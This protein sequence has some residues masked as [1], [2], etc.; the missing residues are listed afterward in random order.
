[1]TSPSVRR[2]HPVWDTVLSILL[3][4]FAFLIAIFSVF[5]QIVGFVFT[6][7]CPRTCN[8]ALGTEYV[9]WTWAVMALIFIAGIAITVVRLTTRHI[10]WWIATIVFVA[11]IAGAITAFGLYGSAVAG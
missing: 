10:A 8:I 1:M 5:F 11:Q 2:P 4:V 9:S 3:L 7:Y 6:D